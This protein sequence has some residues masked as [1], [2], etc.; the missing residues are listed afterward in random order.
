[1]VRCRLWS[2]PRRCH[3]HVGRS[4]SAPSGRRNPQPVSRTR[5]R[6]A[7]ARQQQSPRAARLLPGDLLLEDRR[8]QRSRHPPGG[9]QRGPGCRLDAPGAAP[10]ST[11]RRA[12]DQSSPSPSSAGTCASSQSAPSPH[13]C[14]RTAD[15]FGRRPRACP[16]R[17]GCRSPTRT[18]RRRR[19]GAPDRA[20]RAAAG[21]R[22]R[23][24]RPAMRPSSRARASDVRGEADRAVGQACTSG[25]TRAPARSS[26][27]A[28]STARSPIT[29]SSMTVP[30]PT[31]APAPIT[32]RRT[33][34][35]AL[36]RARRRTP[37]CRRRRTPAPTVTSR[38][39]VAPPK[40]CASGSTFAPGQHQPLARVRGLPATARRRA[41]GRPSRPRSRPACRSRASSRR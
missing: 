17:P 36:E 38:P 40:I 3:S 18:D 29:A 22:W 8:H 19:S 25:H 15:R 9:R 11:R 2:T 26:S 7:E 37:R 16:A 23:A 12:R 1:M 33:T 31:T 21:R 6:G 34:A 20:A 24:G 35:P 41:P 14:G 13:A 30:A 4:S 32:E 27:R 5:R 10:A 39:I 28:P